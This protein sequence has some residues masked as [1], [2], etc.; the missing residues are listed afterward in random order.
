MHT[1]TETQKSRT[2]V[3]LR[4]GC[5]KGFAVVCAASKPLVDVLKAKGS[6]T[7]VEMSNAFMCITLDSIARWGFGVDMKAV[8]S[9]PH[10]DRLPMVE[11]MFF[12]LTTFWHLMPFWGERYHLEHCVAW[13]GNCH[14][15]F[16]LLG[17]SDASLTVW[18]LRVTIPLCMGFLYHA[19]KMEVETMTSDSSGVVH[20][21]TA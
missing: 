3:N 10:M 19:G 15:A 14:S 11:V 6:K 18:A 5:R 4:V 7:P 1:L 9:L 21:V 20:S 16:L 2:M 13:T 12:V 8:Q 17:V